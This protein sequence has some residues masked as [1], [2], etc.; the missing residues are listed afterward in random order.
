MIVKLGR[1]VDAQFPITSKMQPMRAISL[2]GKVTSRPHNGIDF[3][4]P[5]GTPIYA[6]ETGRVVRSGWENE[7][8]QKQGYGLRLYQEIEVPE[9]KFF[10]IY[11]HLSEAFAGEGGFVKKGDVLAFS[12]NTGH[13]TG[14]H[15]HIGA[16]ETDT[17]EWWD[18]DFEV[19]NKGD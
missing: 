10:I 14:P 4:C 13:S 2:D 1:P 3:G 15:L 17:N 8:D 5:I 18:M 16:R 11:A 12:G 7:K 6:V 19:Q 9:G